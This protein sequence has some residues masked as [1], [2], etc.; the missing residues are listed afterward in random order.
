MIVFNVNNKQKRILK[1]HKS[2]EC[3][4]TY[5]RDSKGN[6]TDEFKISNGDFVMLLNYYKYIKEKD[7]RCDFLNPKGK[8][9]L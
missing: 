1:Q 6:K 4:Y 7:I 8:E 3:V 2:D 9:C 5:T